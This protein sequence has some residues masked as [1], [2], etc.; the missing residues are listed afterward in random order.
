MA[1]ALV[2][3]RDIRVRHGASTV[4]D[5]RSLDVHDGEVVVI[6]GPNGAGKST[7]LRVIGLL[8]PPTSGNVHFRGELAT[9]KNSLEMRRRMASVFQEPLLLDSTVYANAALGLK[10]RGF[11]R[12]EIDRKLRPWLERLEIDRLSARRVRTLSGGEAQRTSLARG[13]VLEPDLLLL[14]E[15]FS[16]LD[17]PT[18]EA[19]LLDLQEI[20]VETRI[21][22]VMV[23]HELQEAAAFG[24]RIGVLSHGKLVQ[25]APA[26]EIFTR[27]LSEEVATIVGMRTQ[28]P[29]IAE[30]TSG[31]M[32]R[33]R[34]QGGTMRVIGDFRPG[35]PVTLC[36]RP[37]DIDLTRDGE[38]QDC[39]KNTVYIR[40]KI[41]RVSPWTAQYRIALHSDCGRL[42]AFV[43]KSRFAELDL[44]KGE[45]V[46]AA[47]SCR[48]VHAVRSETAALSL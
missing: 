18:R 32:T 41:R 15:P 20:L 13:L 26:P 1:E 44:R 42:I 11:Q 29:G 46:F 17:A 28:I 12:D 14:D 25:L 48:V 16:A 30:E 19:L 38:A 40:A 23:T 34:F 36:I 45:D 4:L 22:T 7:L 31:G 5:L 27:P 35:A 3:L 24:Q 33:V 9:P 47:L 43:S 10:L 39:P 6:I 21:T 8:Q 2:A 37:E